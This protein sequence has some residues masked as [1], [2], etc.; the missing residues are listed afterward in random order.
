MQYRSHGV[1]NCSVS[2]T[3]A[4]ISHQLSSHR[5]FTTYNTLMGLP[6]FNFCIS[7]PDGLGDGGH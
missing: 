5:I 2:N 4:A 1:I 7:L 6:R 3:V